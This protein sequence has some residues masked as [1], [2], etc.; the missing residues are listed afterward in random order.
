MALLLILAL[1]LAVA[2]KGTGIWALWN[3]VGLAVD[4]LPPITW[5]QSAIV[6]FGLL[7]VQGTRFD[8]S[9]ISQLRDDEE[10]E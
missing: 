8:A 9:S 10:D 5:A 6:G 7:L 1:V 3:G 2:I 4:A